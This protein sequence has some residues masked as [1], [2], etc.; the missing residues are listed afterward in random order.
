[1]TT[2]AGSGLIFLTGKKQEAGAYKKVGNWLFQLMFFPGIGPSC[3][4]RIN[5]LPSIIF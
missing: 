1:M 3:H 5:L 2:N 4:K